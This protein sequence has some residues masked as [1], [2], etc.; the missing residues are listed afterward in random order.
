[1]GFTLHK[2]VLVILVVHAL[3]CTIEAKVQ[4]PRWC[5]VRSGVPRP[6]L[7]A[8]KMYCCERMECP[9]AFSEDPCNR[10]IHLKVNHLSV[11]VSLAAVISMAQPLSQLRTPVRPSA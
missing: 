1:M 7:Y 4:R 8:V 5:V 10:D 11:W 2:L 3:R 6:E 9:I